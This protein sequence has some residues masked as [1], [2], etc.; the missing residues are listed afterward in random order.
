MTN[1]YLII[2]YIFYIYI[3]LT[4]ALVDLVMVI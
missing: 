4:K 3:Y 1:I 2:Y